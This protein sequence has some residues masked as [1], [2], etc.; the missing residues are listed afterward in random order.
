MLLADLQC[1][2]TVVK[3]V[4]NK[5]EQTQN[6]QILNE[7]K[8]FTLFDPS[9]PGQCFSTLIPVVQLQINSYGYFTSFPTTF[10]QLTDYCFKGITEP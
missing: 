1:W 2:F 6:D 3:L 8:C 7:R 10:L 5:E 4:K 9:W